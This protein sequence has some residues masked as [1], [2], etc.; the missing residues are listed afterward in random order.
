MLK[1]MTAPPAFGIDCPSPFCMKAD[2]LLQMSGMAFVREASDPRMGPKKKLPVLHDGEAI[3]SDTFFI[4]RHLEEAHG[5]RYGRGLDEGRRA[6]TQLLSST[7]EEHLYWAQVRFRWDDHPIAVRDGLFGGVPAVVRPFVF[8]MVRK[9]VRQALWGQGLGRHRRDEVLA[10]TEAPLRAVE[11]E[12]GHD[13]FLGGEAP[14]PA[15]G[16][17]YGLI[18]N[19]LA[20]AL[21][22]PLADQVRGFPNLLAHSQRMAEQFPMG[23]AEGARRAA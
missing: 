1:L 22:S 5:A 10:L 15:D 3:I 16:F 11:H 12:L 2:V 7:L 4:Q 21:P 20:P 17:L 6:R 18:T 9:Q 8:N 13:P 19:I 23:E 14:V